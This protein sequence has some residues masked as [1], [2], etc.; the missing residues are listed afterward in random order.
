M[1][2]FWW[3]VHRFTGRSLHCKVEQPCTNTLHG[4]SL[5][6]YIKHQNGSIFINFF[7]LS[8]WYTLG[9]CTVLNLYE[10]M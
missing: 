2:H 9:G 5:I 1:C 8:T 4:E 7:F 10:S 3:D 6:C